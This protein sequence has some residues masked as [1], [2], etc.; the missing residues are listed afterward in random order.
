MLLN[1]GKDAVTSRNGMLTT[2]AY[3]LG[4]EISYALEA[5]SSWR[6]PP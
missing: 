6:E 4:G 5:R 3:Q 2:I 1:T